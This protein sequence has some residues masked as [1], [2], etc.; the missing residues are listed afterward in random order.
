MYLI[1]SIQ[2]MRQDRKIAVY[3]CV[4]PVSA[5]CRLANNSKS[6]ISIL[7]FNRILL[8]INQVILFYITVQGLTRLPMENAACQYEYMM[9]A[10][11]PDVSCPDKQT[12]LNMLRYHDRFMST[13]NKNKGMCSK[14]RYPTSMKTEMVRVHIHVV[15]QIR[16]NLLVVVKLA[17]E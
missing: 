13:L 5:R 1:D 10:S 12:I 16:Y 8:L 7:Q 11:Q 6:K 2:T 3:L 15:V 9:R 4:L 14:M 17:S